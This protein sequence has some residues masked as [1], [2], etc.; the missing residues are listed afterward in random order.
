PLGVIAPGC[1]RTPRGHGVLG[2][3]DRATS[4]SDVRRR[5]PQVTRPRRVATF[6][7]GVLVANG[8]P[9][10]ATAAGR[11]QHLTPIAGPTS[12]AVTNGIWGACNVAAGC[13]LAR[14]SAGPERQ[15]DARLHA[16]EAGYLAMAT[17]M[18]LSERLMTV[19]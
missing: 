12:S 2:A 15:W 9:H 10:L 3:A 4:T 1:S 18:T 11:Q 6:V 7:V 16:F 17:W 14:I 19:N 8:A 13:L 5:R